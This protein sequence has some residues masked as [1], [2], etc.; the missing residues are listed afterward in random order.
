M[1]KKRCTVR[2]LARGRD[3]TLRKRDATCPGSRV[4]EGAR[5]DPVPPLPPPPINKYG[6]GDTFA[7]F[8]LVVLLESQH[9]LK[10]DS[11]PLLILSSAFPSTMPVRLGARF[12]FICFDDSQN[13]ESTILFP[14]RSELE[15]FS[16]FW[17]YCKNNIINH[18]GKKKYI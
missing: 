8:T 13:R 14:L 11:V 2:G 5:V 10:R 17:K 16:L 18:E 15:L 12:T 3:V 9:P 6:Q 4:F 7:R 1:G